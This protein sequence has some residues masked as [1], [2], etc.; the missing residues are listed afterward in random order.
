MRRNT[1]AAAYFSMRQ[2]LDNRQTEHL[3]IALRQ[4]VY[5]IHQLIEGGHVR[6]GRIVRLRRQVGCR[7]F[8]KAYGRMA[9]GA[10]QILQGEVCDDGGEPWPEAFGLP[11]TSDAGVGQQERVVHQIVSHVALR[12][13]QRGAHLPQPPGMGTVKRLPRRLITLAGTA[14]ERLGRETGGCRHIIIYEG[15]AAQ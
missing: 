7:R 4:L 9:P 5:Q 12:A 10:L 13:E 1:Q 14:D 2:P 8:V 11:Q 3:P 6:V 15:N